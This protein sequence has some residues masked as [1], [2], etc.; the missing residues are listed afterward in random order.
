MTGSLQV[1]ND[2]Y[3]I[4][5]NTREKGKRKQKWIA[6]GLDVKNN[7]RR[8]EQMLRD[9]LAAYEQRGGL[10]KSDVLFAAYI[11]RWLEQ[12]RKQV[13]EVTYQGYEILASRHVLPYFEQNGIK[14]RD[15]TTDELQVYFDEKARSGRLDGTGGLSPK[16]LRHHK[17][18]IYQ[19]LNE[20]VRHR[21]I[22]SN[23]CQYVRLPQR[24]QKEARYYNARELQALF[25]AAEGDVLC[26]LL[27]ITVIYG[28]RRSELLGLK[29]DSIDFERGTVSIK[30]T[31]TKVSTLVEKE[32]TKNKSSRRTFP[33]TDEARAIF[34]KTKSD[35]A[36]NRKAF[37]RDYI[38]NDYVFKWDNGQTFSPD[39]I[40]HHFKDL[41]NKHG[42]P[43]IR[44]HELR[45]SCA[46]LLINAGCP[47]KDVQ[48]WMGHADIRMTA[49][50]YGHLD[51]ARKQGVAD[52]MTASLSAGC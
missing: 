15:V 9:Q 7:K 40:S 32:K 46:S 26:P 12:I 1:K 44:F 4:L 31:V 17:N 38:E 13:D 11:R 48:E 35:E 14:L 37:G 18:I 49:D 10:F 30:H 25:Y 21:L 43:H 39:F 27:R 5:I 3:Y 36:D 22:P 52:K 45:H 33:L 42:L 50:L 47:L 41:L 16:S 28:L 6:T 24:Q 19:A 2:K 20:A 51:V 8:A 29:W 23:P 34:Q